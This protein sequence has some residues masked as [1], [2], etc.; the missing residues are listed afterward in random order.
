MRRIQIRVC[1]MEQLRDA[2]RLNRAKASL[3]HALDAQVEARNDIR[4]MRST[5]EKAEDN[6]FLG[7]VQEQLELDRAH[8]I[9]KKYDE[10]QAMMD[11]WKRQEAFNKELKKLEAM[12]DGFVV[13]EGGNVVNQDEIALPGG[14]DN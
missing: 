3:R 9:K 13:R 4:N 7:C 1:P 11:T 6:Y 14:E 10:Q 12:R 2:H 5:I 8:R